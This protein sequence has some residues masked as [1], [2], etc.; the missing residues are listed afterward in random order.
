MTETS[1]APTTDS[2]TAPAT[3]SATSAA[4][5][6]DDLLWRGLVQDSTDLDRL[7]VLLGTP[8]ATF[9]CGFDPTGP[10]LHVGH[11]LQVVTARRLQQAGHRPLLLVGGATGLIGDPK[12]GAERS[13]VERDVAA[14]WGSTMRAQMEPF[15][16]FTGDAA[17]QMVNNVDWTAP[18]STIDFL[19]DV[20]KHFSVNRMLDRDAVSRRLDSAAGISYTEFSYVLLQAHDYVELFRRYDCRLQFGGSD[21]WG[22]ITAG[23]DLVRRMESEHVHAFTTP[24]LL[25]SDGTKYG[26]TEGGAVWLSPEL[27]SP[28]AFYQYWFNTDDADVGML[29]RRLTFVPKERILELDELTATQPAR[30]AAQRAL[31]SEVTAAVHGAAAVAAAEAASAAL[32]GRGSLA[33]VDAATLAAALATVPHATLEHASGPESVADVLVQTGLSPSKGAAR[34]AASE[35]GVY[36]NNERVADADVEVTSLP[37]LHGRWLVLRRGRRTVAGVDVSATGA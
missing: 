10:S 1:D 21:Q 25:K 30:R 20:G 34:R 7:R 35:G 16:D 29:L 32:F 11:L 26:K 3:G 22:N 9:Y 13:L 19:R 4:E 37:L 31:A 28:Y 15:F 27:T 23:V 12:P 14:T 18:L 6:V 2:A 8:G 5:L 24:L 36:A 33:D 17:A